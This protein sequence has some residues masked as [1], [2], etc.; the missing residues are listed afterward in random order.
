[1]DKNEVATNLI[2]AL[3]EKGYI[4]PTPGAGQLAYAESAANH[5]V[6]AFNIIYDGIKA[7]DSN[8]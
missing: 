8:T 6:R 2:L 3:I 4:Q 1:M 7:S 5:V